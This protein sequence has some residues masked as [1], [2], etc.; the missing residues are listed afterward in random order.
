MNRP[1]LTFGLPVFTGSLL[2]AVW[3]AVRLY[4]LPVEQRFLLPA[5]DAVLGAFSTHGEQL[6]AATLST[7]RGAALGFASAVAG[8][9]GAPAAPGAGAPAADALEDESTNC[10]SAFSV[11]ALALTVMG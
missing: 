9:V 10:S 4:L 3:Y 11:S 8:I 7:A 5:P 1:L 6:W 2:I